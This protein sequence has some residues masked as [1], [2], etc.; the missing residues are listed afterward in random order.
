MRRFLKVG[1]LSILL[2]G[3][4][5]HGQFAKGMDVGR[6][7]EN[8]QTC[9]AL[10]DKNLTPTNVPS[11]LAIIKKMSLGKDQFETTD[12]YN[13]RLSGVLPG[14]PAEGEVIALVKVGSWFGKYDADRGKLIVLDADIHAAMES[15]AIDVVSPH[16]ESFSGIEFSSVRKTGKSYVGQNAYG[17]KRRVTEATET[18]YLI[19]FQPPKINNDLGPFSNALELDMAPSLAKSEL[20]FLQLVVLGHVIE[21]FAIDD[22]EYSGATIDEPTELTI[23]KHAVVINS[24]CVGLR[25]SK[26][27]AWYAVFQ[28]PPSL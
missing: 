11:L 22:V 10:R 20:P 12:A 6:I 16:Y 21:P 13:A 17:V 24:P 25:S 15:N 8:D 14:L 4:V 2:S 18:K 9:A 27:G 26:T 1:A 19:A 7:N 5:A 23:Q 28:Y 3:A